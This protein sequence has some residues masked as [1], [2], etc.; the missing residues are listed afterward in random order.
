MKLLKK[1]KEHSR[2][3]KTTHKRVKLQSYPLQ[4]QSHPFEHMK[5]SALSLKQ[6]I[7]SFGVKKSKFIILLIIVPISRLIVTL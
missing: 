7:T 6:N 4:R 2:K 1:I 3:S 5:R